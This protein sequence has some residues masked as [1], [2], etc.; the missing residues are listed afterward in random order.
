MRCELIVD[1]FIFLGPTPPLVRT[2]FNY[3]LISTEFN[4]LG[5]FGRGEDMAMSLLSCGGIVSGDPGVLLLRGT[6][7]FEPCGLPL[8][9]FATSVVGGLLL[10]STMSILA[11]VLAAWMCDLTIFRLPVKE[12]EN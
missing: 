1:K 11:G 12:S 10:C 6:L 9:G 8:Y 4:S 2:K 7:S 3:I 5:V